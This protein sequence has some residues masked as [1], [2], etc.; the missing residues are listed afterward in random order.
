[1]S[2]LRISLLGLMIIL[3]TI[4]TQIG[5]LVLIITL[6]FSKNVKGLFPKKWKQITVKFLLFLSLYS[7]TTFLIVPP[8]AKLNGRVPLPFYERGSLKPAN[9]LTCFFNRHYVKKEMKAA[10]LATA[11]SMNKEYPGTTLN[12]LD[13]NFPFFNKFPLFPHLSH[14]DG[15]KLDLSFLYTNS[16]TGELT[17]KVPSFTGYGISEEPKAGEENMPEYCRQKGYWQYSLIEKITPQYNKSEFDFNEK[18]TKR[19]MQILTNQPSIRKIFIE[20][21]LKNRMG[22]NHNKIRFH[23]CGAV[24][25]DDH[26]H[27]QL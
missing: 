7:I 18:R 25:H 1:M 2:V 10:I 27:I 24:R 9:K 6:L 19:L 23:G 11:Q 21:H 15:E 26:I 14:N 13:S 22:L 4:L 17:T 20:P 3:L 5:G 16:E 12:Y 8:L